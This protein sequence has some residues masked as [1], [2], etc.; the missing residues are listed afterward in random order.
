MKVVR[1]IVDELPKEPTECRFYLNERSY[2]EEAFTCDVNNSKQCSKNDCPLCLGEYEP[3]IEFVSY[4][5]EYPCLCYG[6]LTLKIDGKLYELKNFLISGGSTDWQSSDVTTGEWEINEEE[7]PEEIRPF[8][9]Q[10]A[11]VVNANVEH[12]CCGGCL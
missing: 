10:I 6:V 1:I 5:G 8:S 7:L 2:E 12:G 9:K 4:T 3:K 11:E